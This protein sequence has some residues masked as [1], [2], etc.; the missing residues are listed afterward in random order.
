MPPRHH[1]VCLRRYK[2]PAVE[3]ISLREAAERLSTHLSLPLPTCERLVQEAVVSGVV[4]VRG[5]PAQDSG[6]P[7]HKVITKDIRPDM[8]VDV[9]V[10]TIRDAPYKTGTTLWYLVDINWLDCIDRYLKPSWAVVPP[11]TKAQ[12]EDTR[13]RTQ[14]NPKSRGRRKRRGTQY[15][16]A[17]GT[18]G[19]NQADLRL[20][21]KMNR[22][23]P[24]HGSA[25]AAALILVDEGLVAGRGGRESK[26]KRLASRFLK[27]R[28]R[29][30]SLKPPETR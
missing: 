25:Y 5:V 12:R 26:A 16:P 4:R 7:I 18:V 30:N 9:S 2:I 28:H 8:R 19:Y 22:L 21:A 10:S 3:W 13:S 27:E 14:H 23:F 6:D 11:A 1:A 15:G 20:Y 17:P 29:R 24:K